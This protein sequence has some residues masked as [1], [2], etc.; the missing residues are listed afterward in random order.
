MLA[1]VATLALVWGWVTRLRSED[2]R[3]QTRNNKR[4]HARM[5][6]YADDECNATR[7][8]HNVK[9]RQV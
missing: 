3:G 6:R 5:I 4:E 2:A 9:L 1:L 7:N 8:I